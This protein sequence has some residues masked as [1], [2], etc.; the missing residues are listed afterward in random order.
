MEIPVKYLI[1]ALA[2]ALL[3][4]TPRRKINQKRQSNGSR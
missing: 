1:V 2:P 4:P 3:P